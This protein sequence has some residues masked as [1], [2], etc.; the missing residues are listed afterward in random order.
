MLSA[1]PKGLPFVL[2]CGICRNEIILAECG[3]D[4]F[5]GAVCITAKELL[6]KQATPGWEFHTQ[7]RRSQWRSVGDNPLDILKWP[8]TSSGSKSHW[9]TSRLKGAK[10]H[11]YDKDVNGEYIVWVFACV[12]DPNNISKE[13]VQTFLTKLVAD[14]EVYREKDFEWLYGPQL[15]CQESFG[16]LLQHYMMQVSNLVQFSAIEKHIET[17]KTQMHKNIELLLERDAKL[18]DLQAE[19]TKLQEM[20]V[21]FQKRAKD[22]KRMKMWQ[23]AKHGM[24]MG[25]AITAGVALVTVPPLIALL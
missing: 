22:V 9:K 12:Y 11:V 1:S 4:S 25:M 15:A 18:E 2:W 24:A 23:D 19:A 5:D 17:A 6:N 21:V 14:T 10:F 13:L 7:S 20:A 8:S 3:E 16:P